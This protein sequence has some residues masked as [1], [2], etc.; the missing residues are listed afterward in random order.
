MARPIHKLTAK[1]IE[2]SHERLLSDGGG[3]YLA[4]KSANA[5]SWI[6]RHK[7]RDIGLGPY[8]L[9]TVC[10][11]NL[12]SNVLV[13]QSANQGIRYNASSSLNWA[14]DRRILG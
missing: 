9:I 12:D 8:P 10:T 2:R 6:F 11:E 14:R 7:L 13:M 4:K 1:Q 5:A 3:L